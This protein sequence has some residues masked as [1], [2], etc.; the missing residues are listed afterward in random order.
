M[1]LL[2]FI[3]TNQRVVAAQRLQRGLVALTIRGSIRFYSSAIRRPDFHSVNREFRYLYGVDS[4]ELKKL[5]L[6]LKNNRIHH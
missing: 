6:P 2:A 5:I 4:I 3:A 1:K